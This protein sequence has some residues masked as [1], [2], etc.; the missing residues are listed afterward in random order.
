MNAYKR[1]ALR[2]HGMENSDRRWVLSNLPGHQRK[3]L[4]D[5]LSELRSLGIPRQLDMHSDLQDGANPGCDGEDAA[6]ADGGRSSLVDTIAKA[7]PL[8]INEVLQ[9]EDE[10]AVAA[11]L[12]LHDW[13]WRSEV[14][15]LMSPSRRQRM[16]EKVGQGKGRVTEKAAEALV[17]LLGE[18]LQCAPSLPKIDDVNAPG[19]GSQGRSWALIGRWPWRR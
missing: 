1:A 8:T 17:Q 18:R 14:I 11:I 2:L 15:D 5:M 10:A 4:L 12:L 3:K 19:S 13:P 9:G 7:S 16:V 6:M